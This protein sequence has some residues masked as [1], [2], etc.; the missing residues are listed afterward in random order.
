MAD[1]SHLTQLHFEDLSA[2]EDKLQAWARS[3]DTTPERLK[4]LVQGNGEDAKQV[5]QLLGIH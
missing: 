1:E 2:H 4:E 5:R 3:L